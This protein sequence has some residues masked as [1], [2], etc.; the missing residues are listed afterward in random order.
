M[1]AGA[2]G[3]FGAK[4]RRFFG[5]AMMAPMGAGGRGQLA[6]LAVATYLE[7]IYTSSLPI[8][9]LPPLTHRARLSVVF[10]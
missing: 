3:T 1:R 4:G 10:N 7:L 2:G 5:W 8:P 9:R 6:A